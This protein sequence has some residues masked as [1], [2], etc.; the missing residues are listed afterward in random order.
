MAAIAL[1][2]AAMTSFPATAEPKLSDTKTLTRIAFGSCVDQKKPQPIWQAIRGYRPDL[3]LFMGDNVYGSIRSRQETDLSR[4]REAY[5]T[6]RQV[7]P[8]QSLRDAVP[9]MAVWDDH[10]FGLNDGGGTFKHK[11]EAQKLFADFWDLPADDPRRQRKGIYHARIVGPDGRRV[12]IILLD[13]RYFRSDLKRTD[14]RGAPGR[15]RYLQDP[16]PAK[17]ILGDTQ[18]RWLEEQLKQPAEIRLIVSSIQVI[19]DGHG[20]ERW[21]NLPAERRRLYDL[22]A[23]SG[24][25]GVIFLSGD[26]HVGAL[27]NV[28]PAGMKYSL[29]EI[30]ASSLN[31]PYPNAKERGPH[32]LG[33]IYGHENFGTIDIDWEA[34]RV[35]IDLR[36]IDGAVVRTLSVPMTSLGY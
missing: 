21:G 14:K 16:D 24:A 1:A 11:A 18:W 35:Q 25:K 26:R 2:A 8:F 9:T 34:R 33:N 17:T 10:D 4:L 32:R 36:D 15:E 6:A 19:A 13:T 7:E 30:T 22:I 3:F 23:R 12:Q 27:Y 5:A 20:W 29:R 28:Q 31:R